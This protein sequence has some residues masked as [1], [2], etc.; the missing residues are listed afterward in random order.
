MSGRNNETDCPQGAGT[1]FA[2]IN[3]SAA[4]QAGKLRQ[5]P[6]CPASRMH[7]RPS[8]F[9][10]RPHRRFGGDTG[11]HDVAAAAAV[12]V[13]DFG[14]QR[15][16]SCSDTTGKRIKQPGTARFDIGCAFGSSSYKEREAAASSPAMPSVWLRRLATDPDPLASNQAASRRI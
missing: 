8:R 10:S 13:H 9:A 12:T 4:G 6:R 2:A 3:R 1:P 7:D 11:S 5:P 14:K 16:T 15:A